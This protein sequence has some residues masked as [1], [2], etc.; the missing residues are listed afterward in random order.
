MKIAGITLVAMLLAGGGPA[1]AQIAPVIPRT[2][3]GRPDFH[4]DWVTRFPPEIFQRIE[5]ATGLVVGDEEAHALMLSMWKHDQERNVS[6]PGDELATVYLLP[7]VKGEWRTSM[8]T[9]PTDGKAPLTAHAEALRKRSD[10][11]FEAPADG[12]ELRDWSERCLSGTGTAPFGMYPTGNIRQIVQTRDHVVI[13]SD[14]SGDTRIVAIGAEHRPAAI[15]TFTGDSVARWEGDVLLVE[16][17]R[18]R[19]EWPE[20]TLLPGLVVGAESKVIER[21]SL[22]GPDELF[23]QFTVED[24]EL[25]KEQWSAEYVMA[26]QTARFLEHA[27][28]EGNYSLGNI[29]RIARAAERQPVKP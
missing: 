15:L 2:A 24:P 21:F 18:L 10:E 7:K 8:L 29:L 28:H 4:G 1:V 13:Y 5:G 3:E 26:R 16:T 20:R 9:S 19:D 17:L 11:M 27:C 23:Y 6:D 12:P 22:L 25:Y 14:D